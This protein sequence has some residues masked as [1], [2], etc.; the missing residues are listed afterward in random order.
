MNNPDS[1]PPAG[2]E[3]KLFSQSSFAELYEQALVGPIFAPWVEPLLADVHLSSGERVLDVACGTGIVARVAR[4]RL[5]ESG[6]VVA[7]DVNSQM[8]AVARR[9][10]P[11]IDWREGDVATLPLQSG[12][13][14]DVVLCQQG[15]QFFP[16]RAAAARQMHRALVQDGRLG[17]STWRPDDEFPLP[18][19]LR[20]IAE[21]HVGAIDDRRHSLGDPGPLEAVL[22]EAGFRDVR[23]QRL[24]R[25]IRFSDGSAFARLNAMALV[26]MSKTSAVLEDQE[27]QRLVGAIARDSAELVRRHTDQAGFAFEIGTN[28]TL[29]RA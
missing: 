2:G 7:V 5:G 19:Q 28:V 18:R 17:I 10:D 20:S 16:D 3:Q 29:A 4:K 27:R 15:F 14:F 11:T 21:R 12:E 25:T 23:S 24:V 13:Q 22:S 8:L 26:S 9:V 1:S 6:T